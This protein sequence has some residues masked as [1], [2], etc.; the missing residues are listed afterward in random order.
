M[1]EVI[2]ALDVGTKDEASGLIDML[3][4]KL[5]GFK[6]GHQLFTACGREIVEYI[7][8]RGSRVF[9]DLKYHDIPNTVA[10][11]CTEASSLGV[12]IINIHASGGSE[13]M[14]TAAGKT[15]EHCLKQGIQPPLIV[16]VTVLTSFGEGSLKE[17]G[18]ECSIDEQV[19]RLALLCRNSGLD[20]VV[21]SP[22]EVKP[23]KET[24]GKEFIT[25]T[26]GIRPAGSDLNDQ[27]R[28]TAPG[29]AVRLGTDFMVIGR[30][31]IKAEDPVKAVELINS[32][33]ASA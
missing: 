11:A 28:V 19:R 24:C 31:L 7:V 25:V 10:S 30:P 4:G 22:R 5:W 26:P 2:A 32:E 16:G 9:L 12:S 17:L 15:K 13:M 14:R 21:C 18:I 29:D 27:K 23:V 33:I 8:R 20:G 3:S 6:V 1:S